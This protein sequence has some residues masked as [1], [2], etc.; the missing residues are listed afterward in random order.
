VSVIAENADIGSVLL[1]GAAIS[2]ATFSAIPGSAFSAAIVSLTSGTHN[3]A[4]PHPHGITVEGYNDFDS[5]SY[6][7]G[8]L[9]QFINPVG[10]ANDPICTAQSNLG[11]PPSVCGTVTDNRPTEDVNHNNLL[12]PGEDLNGNGLID[13]DTGIFFVQLAPGAVNLTLTVDPFVPGAGSVNYCVTL[14]NPNLAGTGEVVATDGAGNQCGTPIS[15]LVNQPPMVSS[16]CSAIASSKL[17]TLTAS[18]D[19][20]AQGDIKIYVLD[21]ATPAFSAGPFKSGDV[22]VIRSNPKQNPYSQALSGPYKAQVQVKGQALLV[23]QDGDGGRSGAS[24]IC[25]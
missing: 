20:T 25:Q 19:H 2:P 14:T 18:D 1:D 16:S 23:A 13:K 3:T 11:P 12:D 24:P 21:S 10:D 15:L 4:S 7:G 9:F 22:L 6:P 17:V 5:Y 8:A